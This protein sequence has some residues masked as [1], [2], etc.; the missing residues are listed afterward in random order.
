MVGGIGSIGMPY[1]SMY[2]PGTYGASEQGFGTEGAEKVD[3]SQECQTCKNRKYVDGSD[4][5]NV[6]FKTPGHIDPKNSAAAVTAHEKMHVANAQKEG[7]KENA[8]L[9]SA[10][11]SLKTAVCPECGSTY[12]SGGETRTMIQYSENNPYEK[13]KKLLEGTYLKGSMVDAYC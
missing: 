10:T 12:V 9:L 6:S 8:K 7:S 5:G 1:G 13:N 3:K 11:V 2:V 4:E